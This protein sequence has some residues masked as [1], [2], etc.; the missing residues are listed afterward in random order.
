MRTGSI[1]TFLKLRKYF[2]GGLLGGVLAT[3]LLF[4][5]TD[6][7]GF[8]FPPLVIFQLLI[9]PVPGSIQ[10]VIV[11]TFRQYAKYSAFV[12]SSAIYAVL[13]GVIAV[14]LGVLFKEDIYSRAR[15]AAFVVGTI[16]PTVMCVGLQLRLAAAFSAISSLYGWIVAI[17]LALAVNLVYSGVVIRYS[18]I[19]AVGSKETPIQ[20][21]LPSRRGFLKKVIIASAL[22]MV[23]GVAS[24]I[25]LSVLSSHPVVTSSTSVPINPHAEPVGVDVPAIFRDSRISDLVGSEVTD[26]G[27]FYRVD[28]NP[29]PPQLSLDTWTLNVHGKVKNPVTLTKDSLETL[30]A[31]DEYA[32]LECVSN[33]IYP[34]GALISNAKWTGIPLAALLNQVGIQTDAKYVVFRSGDGYSVGVP[35]ER[36]LLPGALLVFKMNGETLPNEHGFPLRAIIPG[37]YGMMNA[38]WITD[39]ELTDGVYLGYWQERGWSNDARIKTTSIIYYPAPNAHVNGSILIAGVAFAGDRSISKVEV[40]VDGG[41]TWKE[42][43]LKSPSS[44]YS[45]VLWAYEWTPVTRGTTMI[46][47]RAYDGKG[48]VQDSMATQP[49]PDGASGYPSV[50]VTVV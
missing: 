46:I 36:A 40:S 42:A 15:R 24:R 29:I 48:Q 7:L 31:M 44:P 14:F 6:F 2:V 47:A 35:L 39:I 9:G 49:F 37:L 12:F 34:P 21:S 5:G 43:T 4:V 30:Q 1:E 22:L 20:P 45:W 10:S 25:G 38:K 3:I 11:D 19:V 33:T 8:P 23:G 50:Q 18:A 41:T 13:Y 26:N 17:L 32:T 27:A 28:I 16:I